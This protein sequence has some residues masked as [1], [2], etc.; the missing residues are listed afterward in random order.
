MN[1]KRIAAMA[2]AAAVSGIL[3]TGAANAAT[4][5]GGHY[6]TNPNDGVGKNKTITVDGD[7]SDWSE[8]MMIAKGVANDDPR[9]FRGSHEGPVYDTYALY[10]AWDDTNLYFMWQYTNVTDVVD[11]SQGYP[12][13]DNGKPWNGDIPIM[14]A[15]NTGSGNT[16][17][18]TATDGKS[19]WGLNVNFTTDVDKV[20][21]FSSKPGVGKPA[22]FSATNG[23]L[24]YD[25]A[26]DFK[27][28]GVTYAYGDGF[29]GAKMDGIKANGYDGYVPA[30]LLSDSS[31]WVNFLDE[32]HDTAQDTMY[33]MKIPLS[34][35]GI[36]KSDLETNGIGAM[37]IST[38]GASGI[39]S[40]PM[41]MTFLDNAT[42]PYTPDESTSGEKEDVDNVTVPLANIGK[43]GKI[44]TVE[45][46]V[47]SSLTAD[48]VSPQYTGTAINFTTDATSENGGLT[49]Q[50]AVN[51]TVVK[52][53]DDSA[54]Y[55][56][57]PTEAGTYTVEVTVKDAKGMTATK[58]MTYV[59]EKPEGI[60]IIGMSANIPSPQS[61]GTTVKLTTNATFNDTLYYKYW[62]YDDQ[63]NWTAINDYSTSNTVDW[64]PAQ[65][66]NYIIW[67]DVKDDDGN[68][69][70]SQMNYVVTG[71]VDFME[72]NDSRV[73]YLGLW[74]NA[75]GADY[76]NGQMA[77][78]D[79]IGSKATIS[80]YGTGVKLLSTLGTDKGIAKITIDGKVYSADMYRS[81][82]MNKGTAFEKT[83]LEKGNHVITIE[84]SGLSSRKSN[85]TIISI[86]S[87]G[88]ME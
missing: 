24:D 80:F 31:N 76:S 85:G 69:E 83:G 82:V 15:L 4:A 6:G 78:T 73:I 42:V 79:T 41:D 44:I 48:K 62:V 22:I 81:S 60:A 29:L 9:I 71:Q 56:W 19:V 20:L 5:L 65:S 28:A 58:T 75:E 55:T 33:E 21:C 10:S 13:S 23:E 64:T 50:Y 34:A 86:D 36:T 25:T 54:D 88:I 2:I 1:R 68:V 77:Y 46:P 52:S 51:G 32:G 57:A 30:D 3:G 59:V 45:K 53:Y 63:G 8:D 16:T 38:F 39:A 7:F 11:P 17:D 37:L 66:G 72:E 43:V 87:I 84:C 74:N 70:S 49:Y 12:I 26:L 61:A 27:T 40:L 14:L 67:V 47:I 35:L 18:G